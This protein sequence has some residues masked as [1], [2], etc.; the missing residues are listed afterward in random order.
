MTEQGP[1]QPSA[2]QQQPG[3]EASIAQ[4]RPQQP[5]WGQP[6]YRPPK[7][8]ANGLQVGCSQRLSAH[9]SSSGSWAPSSAMTRPLPRRTPQP[10]TPTTAVP[11]TTV[12]P[13]DARDGVITPTE[14][15]YLDELDASL[16]DGKPERAISRGE[17][18]CLDLR[19]GREGA[20]VLSKARKRFGSG[21]GSDVPSEEARRIVTTARENLCPTAPKLGPV[22]LRVPNVTNVSLV[23]AYDRLEKAGMDPI[24]GVEYRYSIEDNGPPINPTNWAVVKQSPA[25]GTKVKEGAKL[26]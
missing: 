12:K 6:G 4:Q 5:R 9:L 11:A 24:D 18:I 1:G 15:M 3:W 13:V 17:D 16:V 26:T 7:P 22:Y 25:P 8:P 10:V 23:D 21:H 20:T 14:H 19:Q 2:P